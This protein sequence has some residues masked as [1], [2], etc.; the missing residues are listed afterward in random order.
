VGVAVW[1][2]GWLRS[3]SACEAGE[4]TLA[5]NL[6]HKRPASRPA[7]PAPL[8]VAPPRPFHPLCFAVVAGL[9]QPTRGAFRRAPGADL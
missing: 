6:A 8:T 4:G 1:S 7:V 5:P 2:G 3:L 9:L